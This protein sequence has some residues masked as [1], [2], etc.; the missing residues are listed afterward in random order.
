M[1]D[2]VNILLVERVDS[3]NHLLHQLHLAV[4]QPVFVRDVV[5]NASLSTRLPT[6]STWLKVKLFASGS[7]NLGAKLGPSW[8]VDVNRS[9]HACS[10]V[11]W[12][13]MDVS[14]PFVQ[15]EVVTRFL[16]DGILHSLD[17]SCQSV[18]HLLDVSAL[19]HGDDPQLVL[20]VDPGQ[21]G[22]V[23]VVED[24]TTL[25]PVPLHASNLEV[26]ITRH[27]EEVVI[28]QLLSDLLTHPSEREVRS[29]EVTFKVSKCL[30]HEVLHINSLLLGDSG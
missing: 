10:K 5:G 8:E 17:T 19:L 11:C 4:S 7:K 28:N 25:G 24:S 27:K 3:V 21:E 6:G 23:L 2:G 20:F 9:S 1:I 12:A 15:H 30:L 13:S 14:V 26:W 18:K 16:L 22:L 29:G